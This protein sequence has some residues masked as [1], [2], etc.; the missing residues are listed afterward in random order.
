MKPFTKTEIKL[1]LLIFIAVFVITSLNLRVALRRARDSQRRADIGAITDALIAFH[2]SYGFF[3]PSQDGK[4][5]I[6]K[7]DNFDE[8]VKDISDDKIFDRNKFFT[9]VVPCDWGKDSFEDVFG[10]GKAYLPTIP[11]DPRPNT[12]ASYYYISDQEFFQ[13]FTYLEGEKAED[14]YNNSVV[15]RSLGCG[16][17]ICSYGKS[18]LDI[19]LGKSI[20]EYRREIE[21]ARN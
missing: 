11:G 9:G 15:G 13:I 20:E 16:I 7:G 8:V 17:K 18:Y 1:T 2:E 4:I 21:D 3:P 12:G 14:T 19:P 5:K 10:S 6:C